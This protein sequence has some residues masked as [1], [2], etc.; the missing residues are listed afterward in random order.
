MSRVDKRLQQIHV[1]DVI[2]QV[3]LGCLE[4][5]KLLS[6]IVELGDVWELELLH[7]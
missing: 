3:L 2:V 1:I 4:P 5:I 7:I 6:T